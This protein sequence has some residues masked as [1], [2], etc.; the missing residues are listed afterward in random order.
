[1]DR[2]GT[3][4]CVIKQ[5]RSDNQNPAFLENAKRLFHEEAVTLEQLGK[6]HDRIPQL[7]AFFVEDESFYL[8][9]D[10]IEGHSLNEELQ[11]GYQ[12]SEEQVQLLLCEILEVLQFIHGQQVIHRDI[13]PDNIIRRKTDNRLVLLDFG[14]VKQILPS[15]A[16]AGSGKLTIAVGT[17]GY[18]PAEQLNGMPSPNSDLYA[19]GIIAIQ[20][21]TGVDP[22]DFQKDPQTGEIVWQSL[23]SAS[24]PLKQILTK[25]V[26]YHF[27]ERYQS[28]EEVLQAL[29]L[30]NQTRTPQALI[31]G[32]HRLFTRQTA[33][34]KPSQSVRPVT[35]R[36]DKTVLVPGTK[37]PQRVTQPTEITQSTST[38]NSTVIANPPAKKS[39]IDEE[40]ASTDP[41]NENEEKIAIHAA[42]AL[43]DGAH[44]PD[45]VADG[46]AVK[47]IDVTV[48]GGHSTVDTPVDTPVEEEAIAPDTPTNHADGSAVQ[49]TA[50]ETSISSP[51]S[52][53]EPLPLTSATVEEHPTPAASAPSRTHITVPL[54]ASTSPPAGETSAASPSFSSADVPL[55]VPPST[56]FRRSRLAIGFG[57]LLVLAGFTVGA[58]YWFQQQQYRQSEQ[59][60]AAIA[61]LKNSKEYDQCIQQA[62]TFASRYDELNQSAQNLLGE[63]RLA[64]AEN[65]AKQGQFEAA[66]ALVNK[67]TPEM[68]S[69]TQ[70]SSRLQG[71]ATTM[72]TKATDLYQ[73]GQFEAAI[74]LLR[75]IPEDTP[76][77]A[78]ATTTL[79]TWE[80]EQQANQKHL[81][82]A[83]QA[84]SNQKWQAALDAINQI[85]ILGVPVDRNSS[86]WKDTLWAIVEQA[87]QKLTEQRQREAEAQAAERAR[88]QEAARDL[89]RNRPSGSSNPPRPSTSSGSSRPNR[90]APTRRL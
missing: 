75:T 27:R 82:E 13:K 41:V 57:G 53:D 40:S 20:A 59:A 35:S 22:E 1:M 56:A 90:V 33:V 58:V 2:P 88:Q 5:L 69:Y 46:M 47:S 87:E 19:L 61:T 60:V 51:K 10:F 52:V 45:S 89:Q 80:A 73:Q 12:W 36:S 50:D 72:L 79:V 43:L 48:K 26:R 16:G 25:M 67:I 49:S 34:F 8:V 23:T 14:A 54:P 32:L 11:I 18:M 83:Q 31:T 55:A 78:Q 66:I 85:K 70:V 24:A 29:N 21:L 44:Q 42:D 28:A 77:T 65:L 15:A 74:D 62:E 17:P 30:L 71:W 37:Q 64:Q 39:L 63:C 9:Q 84:V 81:D 4:L 38:Q 86:Y 7:L 3:P 6:K 76:T 68:T